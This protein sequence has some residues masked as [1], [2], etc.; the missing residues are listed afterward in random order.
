MQI[1]KCLFEQ[2]RLSTHVAWRSYSVSIDFA[3]SAI[4]S[5]AR[6]IVGDPQTAHDNNAQH[7]LS[8]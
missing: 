1:A 4:A 3:R 6:S 2:S 8:L 7:A 5:R